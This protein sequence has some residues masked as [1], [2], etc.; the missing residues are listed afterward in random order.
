MA[1][2]VYIL[3]SQI[4]GSYYIGSTQDLT[5]RLERHN[6]GRSLY[7]KAKLPWKLVYKEEH[8]D[9]AKAV[10]RENEIKARKRKG[11]IASLVRTSRP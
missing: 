3:K 7:T 6:Q 8:P 10:R 5:E 2:Y 11:Y 1:Y 4:D 9:R